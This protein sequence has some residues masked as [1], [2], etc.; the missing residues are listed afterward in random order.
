[1]KRIVIT[2]NNRVFD[3]YMDRMDVML[4]EEGSYLD[5]LNQAAELIQK[6]ARLLMHPLDGSKKPNQT[7]Y[8]SILLG[9]DEDESQ[10]DEKSVKLIETSIRVVETGFGDKAKNGWKPK[11]QR[12]LENADLSIVE[13]IV[14][15]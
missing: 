12:I 10:I 3:R 7:P 6:G 9:M 8:K 14:G 1:M 13:K 11:L 2:N 5:V 15:K 4:L